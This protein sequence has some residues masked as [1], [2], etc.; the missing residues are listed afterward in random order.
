MIMQP[1]DD[2]GVS[3]FGLPALMWAL[4]LLGLY[5]SSRYSD[6]L[7]HNLVELTGVLV[8]LL[9]FIVFITYMNRGKKGKK[10]T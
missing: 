9:I 3:K 5:A 4:V 10:K 7:F 8:A 2:H 1:S 6:L